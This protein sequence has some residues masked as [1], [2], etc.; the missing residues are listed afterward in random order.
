MLYPFATI[1]LRHATATRKAACFVAFVLLVIISNPS[2]LA[3]EQQDSVTIRSGDDGLGQTKRSGTI[4]D[5]TRDGL[6]IRQL[7]GKLA[8]IPA[9]K[10]ISVR[11]QLARHHAAGDRELE[12]G[13]YAEA[14][15]AYRRQL[16]D[17]ESETRP[18]VLGRLL[19]SMI[20]AH[21]QLGKTKDAA[22]VFVR[23]A[24]YRPRTP[25]LDHIPL[26]W[27]AEPQIDSNTATTWLA[28]RK[29]P[30]VIL[31]GASHLI[32]TE[33]RAS[34][35]ATL[36]QLRRNADP[37]IASLAQAQLWRTEF[38]T[39]K[40]PTIDKWQAAIDRMPQ[41]MRGGPYF[42]LAQAMQRHNRHEE[43][44]LLAMRVPIL[45]EYDRPLAAEA[46]LVA[47]KSLA[48]MEHN[49]DAVRVFRE[50]MTQ[51]PRATAAAEAEQR[52]DQITESNEAKRASP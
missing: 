22:D 34:A 3:A 47:G 24:A 37:W 1:K 12:A 27:T 31:L 50:L 32:A 41:T 51:Y 2:V 49:D 5:Y 44:A 20:R 4:E 39:A 6:R 29:Y 42:V 19:A 11:T 17:K 13:R 9:D 43:A 15:A 38:V 14:L 33:R 26:A 48:K 23:L 35:V 40:E 52:I 30:A 10:V 8:V 36:E 16:A 7:S 45:Y 25:Y 18:W 28:A 21:Q 46:L